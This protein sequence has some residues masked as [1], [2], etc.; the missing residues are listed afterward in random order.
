RA[1]EPRMARGQL[2]RDHPAE[3]VADDDGL[4]D[5]LVRADCGDVV[6]ETRDAVSVRRA[7]AAAAA[8][9]LDDR[10]CMCAPEMLHLGCIERG[11]AAPAVHEDELGLAC[12]VPLVVQ[13]D[14]V[15]LRV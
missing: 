3:A 8:A 10:H 2:D 6:G 1:C 9:Q 12:T 5:P 4:P 7:V 14:A 15:P 13:P 11:V